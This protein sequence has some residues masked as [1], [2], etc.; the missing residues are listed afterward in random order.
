MGLCY[1][2]SF[3]LSKLSIFFL[4]TAPIVVSE[5]VAAPAHKSS[6]SKS[7]S[8]SNKGKHSNTILIFGISAGIVVFAIIFVLIICSCSFREGK[9]KASPEEPGMC[10]AMTEFFVLALRFNAFDYF[11]KILLF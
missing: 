1:L 7:L 5:P 8:T 9:T 4:F 10:R 11:N 3:I 6:N 2:V